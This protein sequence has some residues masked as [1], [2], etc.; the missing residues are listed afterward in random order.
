MDPESLHPLLRKREETKTVEVILV[1]PN[2]GL[3]GGLP[4]SLNRRAAQFVIDA[5]V[6]ARVVAVGKKGRDF[7]RRTGQQL[8]AEFLDLGDYPGY[9]ELRPVAQIAMQDFIEGHADEVYILYSQFV[10]TVVQKP[11]LLKLLP[12][13]APRT[14]RLPRST[15]SMSRAGRPSWPN[16]CRDTSSGRYTV[17]SSRP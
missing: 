4:T 15:T 17:P 13:E 6:P 10:N 12:V 1:T 5:G 7:M 3:S 16:S 2:R 9:E 8:V 11:E 14:L